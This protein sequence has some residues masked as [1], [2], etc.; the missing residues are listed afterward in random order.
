M[1]IS[2]SFNHNGDLLVLVDGEV[3]AIAKDCEG[4]DLIEAL[5]TR[6]VKKD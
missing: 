5:A 1:I 6:P 4:F 2:F 3:Q